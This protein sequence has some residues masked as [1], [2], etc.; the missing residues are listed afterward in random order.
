MA[1][2]DFLQRVSGGGQ[3]HQS[4]KLTDVLDAFQPTTW[5]VSEQ[6]GALLLWD[7]D[8]K[9]PFSI[10]MSKRSV[11]QS[12]KTASEK[13]IIKNLEI[14]EVGQYT[15]KTTN[16]EGEEIE[17]LAT[18]LYVPGSGDTERHEISSLM[19]SVGVE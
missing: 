2:F 14:L 16:D 15:L 13:F 1:K 7:E 10:P 12:N 8:G 11:K 19:A 3:F 5:K 17:V 4:E 6:N 9:A 18:T